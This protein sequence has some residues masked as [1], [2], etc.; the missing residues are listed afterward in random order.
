M[1]RVE[2][3]E[4]KLFF[5]LFA[6]CSRWF[7]A[8][9]IDIKPSSYWQKKDAFGIFS[10]WQWTSLAR[11]Y[12]LL[13]VAERN[14]KEDYIHLYKTLFNSADIKESIVLIQSLAFVPHAEAFIEK[15]RE[16]A[17]SNITTMF[18]AVAHNSNYAF[19]HFDEAG[20][21]QLVLKAAFLNVPIV[22]IYGLKSRNNSQLV[23]ML[24]DYASERQV[25]SRSVPWD[26]WCCV[27][28]AAD[29]EENYQ[30]LKAQFDCGDIK[31]K[32]A[33]ALALTENQNEYAVTLGQQLSQNDT[34]GELP[35]P[36]TW[37]TISTYNDT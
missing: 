23:E 32:A 34:L 11:L 13:L 6:I 27:A 18:I 29:S 28:W 4:Q 31:T 19:K 21:N 14:T 36:L 12:I 3:I 35:N 7:D 33:I 16:A 17:R 30:Y 24:C 25:A 5:Y 2:I 37:E 15:A 10:T 20:W 1:E 8:K 26:L 9:N 22:K